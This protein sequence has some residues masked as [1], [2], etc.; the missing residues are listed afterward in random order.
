MR[1]DRSK[2]HAGTLRVGITM[3]LL[4]ALSLLVSST[5]VAAKKG[6]GGPGPRAK[7]SNLSPGQRDKLQKHIRGAQGKFHENRM[8]L[9]DARLDLYRQFREYRLDDRRLQNSIRKINDLQLRLLKANLDNQMK[10]RNILTREQFESLREAV[11]DR[12]TDWEDGRVW[13]GDGPG[14]GDA[15]RLGLSAEQRNRIEKLW[16]SSRESASSLGGRL[17][18]DTESL[19]RRYLDYELNPKQAA[20]RIDGLSDTQLALLKATVARQVELRKILTERQFEAL[21]KSVPPAGRGKGPPP[22]KGRRGR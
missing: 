21:S 15:D 18:A 7:I 4:I 12:D 3:L 20:S 16:K 19:Q 10:L 22:G 6:R 8:E 1:L 17:R 11:E 5:S 13:P 9:R 14:G 2:S